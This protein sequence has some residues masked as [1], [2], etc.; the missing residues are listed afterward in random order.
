MFITIANVDIQHRQYCLSVLAPSTAVISS[1][2]CS[3]LGQ[4]LTRYDINCKTI[5]LI[6]YRILGQPPTETLGY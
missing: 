2:Y 5:T 6:S 3:N 1:K 4:V